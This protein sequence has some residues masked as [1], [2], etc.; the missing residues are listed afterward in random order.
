MGE[1][2]SSEMDVAEHLHKKNEK[3]IRGN[4]HYEEWE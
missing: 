1:K 4:A 2:K 3:A